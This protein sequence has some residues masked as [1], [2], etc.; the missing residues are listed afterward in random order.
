MVRPQLGATFADAAKQAK[1]VL[2]LWGL[3]VTPLVPLTLVGA[4]LS[5]CAPSSPDSP[6]LA[7]VNGKAI[8]QSEFDFRW[9]ELPESTRAHYESLGG[10]KKFLDDLISREILLQEARRLGLDH[11]LAFRTRIARIKEQLLLDEFMKEAASMDIQIPE[12][13][14]EAYY[15]LNRSAL[16]EAQQIRAA[17]IL[18]PTEAQAKELKYQL[19]QGYSFSK[20]AQ[21]YSI[22][23]TTRA[24]GGEFGI[25]RSGMA[26][27]GI[28]R[29][30]LTLK[31]G[32]VSDPIQT[33]SGFHLVKVIARDADEAQRMEAARQR[34]KRELYA[35]K[36]RKQF[37]EVLAKLR[38]TATV[39]VATT[40]GLS[41]ESG[42][43]PSVPTP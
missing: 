12:S 37:E 13:E 22:D 2:L 36:R 27:P 26:D 23:E 29:A 41:G 11:S 31:P 9:S 40:S 20:L 1:I 10:K 15:D 4:G 34:L 43:V 35:E 38:A 7:V 14:L 42:P 16:L 33:P 32:V 18:V 19:S 30:L 25:Y 5:G 39:R 3:S 28:E 8:T 24:N 17:H 21:R 6:V